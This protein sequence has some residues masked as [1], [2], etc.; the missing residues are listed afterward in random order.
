M[1]A[2]ARVHLPSSTTSKEGHNDKDASDDE[3]S[4]DHRGVNVELESR[5]I[6]IRANNLSSLETVI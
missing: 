5:G 2:L 6:N 3:K 4:V 1:W